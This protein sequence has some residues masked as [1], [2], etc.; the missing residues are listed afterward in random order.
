M[1]RYFNK[2]NGEHIKYGEWLA[3]PRKINVFQSEKLFVRRTGDYPFAA[4]SNNEA[5]GNATV[6][7]V[8]FKESVNLY[9]LKYM[10]GLINSKLMKWFFQYENFYIVGK[11][12]GTVHK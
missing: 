2:W 1:G 3:E 12:L 11:P 8:Y 5:I 9:S 4:Y 10:L 7:C 6:H